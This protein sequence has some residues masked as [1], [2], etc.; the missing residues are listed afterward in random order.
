FNEDEVMDIIEFAV[1]RGITPRFIEKMNFMDDGLEP[2]SLGAVKEMLIRKEVIKP[3][4]REKSSS[5][6]EYYE[7]IENCGAAGFITP[8]SKPFCGSCDKIRIKSNGELSLCLF[9]D[10]VSDLRDLLKDRVSES[11]IIDHIKREIYKK[12]FNADAGLSGDIMVKIG[13]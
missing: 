13:G 8:N 5:V 7:F 9:A 11:N 1:C 2:V 12:P 4:P 6:A 10:E 3:Y